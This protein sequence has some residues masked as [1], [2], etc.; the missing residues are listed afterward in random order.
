MAE[1]SQP[2]LPSRQDFYYNLP[3]TKKIA[4]H[5]KQIAKSTTAEKSI[6]QEYIK[7]INEG[8]FTRDENPK[9]HFCVYFAA[10]DP[11]A[12]RV[13]V[14]H[15]KK[16]GLWLFNGG[17]IDEGELPSEALEREIGEEWGNG[18]KIAN[19][20]SP[21]LLT[22]TEINNPTKQTCKLHYD[23]W[24][25]IPLDMDTFSPDR[26]LLETEFHQTDWKTIQKAKELITDANTLLALEEIEKLFL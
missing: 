11:Q 1:V 4:E 8:H 23:I 12:K 24:N 13:F 3:M 20:Y 21:A 19:A 25:F 18:I 14:G 7:R 10:F 2:A 17:H 6:R 26:A 9:T 16:S 22:V 15:H 5:L